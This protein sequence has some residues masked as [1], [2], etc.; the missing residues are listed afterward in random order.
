VT[1]NETNDEP[2]KGAAPPLADL[3]VKLRPGMTTDDWVKKYLADWGRSGFVL[4]S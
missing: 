3:I 2:M 4:F 1:V